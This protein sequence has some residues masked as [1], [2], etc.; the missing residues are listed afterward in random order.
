MPDYHR[1]DLGATYYF[2][3]SA[4]KEM[5]LTFSIYNAYARENAYRISFEESEANPNVTQANKLALFSIVPS[6]SFNFKF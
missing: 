2:T 1:L 6:I 3:K 5:S 4:K